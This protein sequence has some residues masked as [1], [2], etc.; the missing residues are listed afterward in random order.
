MTYAKFE[1]W[2][3]EHG[4]FVRAGG[5]DYEKTFAWRGYEAGLAS[6]Q[7]EGSNADALRP[8]NYVS[9]GRR[10][11]PKCRQVHSGVIDNDGVEQHALT[12]TKES[13]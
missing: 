11:C 5:G 4:Q 12:A 9:S 1:M 7:G 10:P 13:P 3:K 8:C 6:V 2:W